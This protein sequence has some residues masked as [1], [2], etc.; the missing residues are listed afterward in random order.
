MTHSTL[1]GSL[2][3]LALG[4]VLSMQIAPAQIRA[5]GN[6]LV[7]GHPETTPGSGATS[8]NPNGDHTPQP[9]ARHFLSGKV[10]M[11]D[12]STPPEPVVVEQFCGAA[13]KSGGH[14]DSKGRFNFQI[15][16]NQEEMVGE[17]AG[18]GAGDV[19]P[20]S[21][22]DNR[23]AGVIRSSTHGFRCKTGEL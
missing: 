9:G 22:A 23:S 12:G 1:P 19:R 20:G 13:R 5:V 7:W 17:D 18:I 4:L 10:M 8:A 16:R 15:G 3:G 14:T 6:T 11:D 21:A 2:G